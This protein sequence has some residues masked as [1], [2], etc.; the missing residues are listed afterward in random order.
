MKKSVKIRLIVFKIL[1]EIYKKSS[2]FDNSYNK[3]VKKNINISKNDRS[4]I[5]NV[6][7]NSIRFQFHITTILN[8]YLKKKSKTN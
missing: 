7:L 3:I 2:N 4:L 8:Q 5:N 6:C 1:L